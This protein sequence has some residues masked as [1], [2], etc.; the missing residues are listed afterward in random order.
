MHVLHSRHA[1]KL[2]WAHLEHVHHPACY[3]ALWLGLAW[4][5]SAVHAAAIWL[6][7]C[8][9]GLQVEKEA[10]MLLCDLL[11]SPQ[12]VVTWDRLAELYIDFAQ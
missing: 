11:Y 4:V 2:W 8:D 9:H 12:R 10:N 7:I 5:R 6:I 3:S 1:R